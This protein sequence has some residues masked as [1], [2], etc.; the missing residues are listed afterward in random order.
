MNTD[1]NT[2]F[3][4]FFHDLESPSFV[5]KP[6]A[7]FKV[8]NIG[9]SIRVN[10]S[11]TGSPLPKILWYKDNVSLP[12]FNNVTT[13]EVTSELV[14]GQFKPSDQATYTCVARNMYN[15]EEKTSTNIGN[16]FIN[17]SISA[18][19]LGLI[20]TFGSRKSVQTLAINLA[21]L[22]KTHTQWTRMF[23]TIFTVFYPPAPKSGLMKLTSV[24]SVSN[25]IIQLS[26][27]TRAETL[28]NVG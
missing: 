9:A 4:L 5:S 26:R 16:A 7:S 20:S 19:P 27:R 3:F 10:C 1:T 17:S 6:P 13:D 11:A 15:D 24:A 23:Y 8:S 12:V 21:P 18:Q 14:I 28:A 2:I 25:R 22:K